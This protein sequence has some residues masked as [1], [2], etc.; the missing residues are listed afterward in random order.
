MEWGTW[1]GLA[2]KEGH[3]RTHVHDLVVPFSVIHI[4]SLLLPLPCEKLHWLCA[5][6]RTN[7]RSACPFHERPVSLLKVFC[8]SKVGGGEDIENVSDRTRTH[9]PVSR[10]TLRADSEARRLVFPFW[11]KKQINKKER[12][13]ERRARARMGYTKARERK[14]L[15]IGTWFVAGKIFWS[16]RDRQ[17]VGFK[18]SAL[19][20]VEYLCGVSPLTY[21]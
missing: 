3:A 21:H 8:E 10:V 5:Y 4:T 19:Y 1:D 6:Y 16:A 7:D 2:R 17:M 15:R 14:V 12:R 13:K 11:K 9:A 18:T 20:I